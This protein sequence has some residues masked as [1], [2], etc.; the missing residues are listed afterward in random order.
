MRV[1]TKFKGTVTALLDYVS[2]SL[3]GLLLMLF[4]YE[5]ISVGI[6]AGTEIVSDAKQYYDIAVA[7]GVFTKEFWSAMRPVGVPLVYKLVDYNVEGFITIQ[8]LAHLLTWGGFA[9]YVFRR[10]RSRFISLALVAVVLLIAI[11]P[12]VVIWN[13]LGL[14]ESLSFSFLPVIA[15]LLCELIRAPKFLVYLGYLAALAFYSMLRDVNSYFVLTMAVAL[16]FLFIG[17]KLSARQTIVGVLVSCILFGF[18]VYT[19]GHAGEPITYKRWY[20]PLVNVI[21]HRVLPDPEMRAYMVKHGM[22]LSDALLRKERVWAG[23][24]DASGFSVYN[25][26]ELVEFREFLGTSGKTVYTRYLIEHPIYV[27]R[28]IWT[29]RSAIFHTDD[30]ILE[31]YLQDGVD[32]DVLAPFSNVK[33][34]W[35]YLGL[36][37]ICAVP[38]VSMIRQRVR[39]SVWEVA[40]VL[41]MVFSTFPLSIVAYYGDAME[42]SRHTLVV[43][44]TLKVALIALA[45]VLYT[46][47]EDKTSDE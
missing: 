17:R 11:L 35:I 39:L 12:D 29:N 32:T 42:I 10:I 3:F 46:A 5:S 15:I 9:W 23:D 36:A 21:S 13:Y 41:T 16:V 31:G 45:I 2:K 19:A 34:S 37:L 4:A 1:E 44:L 26:P 27:L 14:T 33:N 47:I 7:F 24:K 8:V 18:S 40:P 28:G 38:I 25:D 22:P 30:F 20:F 43:S 6:G